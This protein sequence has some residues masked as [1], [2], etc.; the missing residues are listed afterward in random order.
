MKFHN[1]TA[2]VFVPDGQPLDRALARVTHLGIGA[3][4]DDLEFGVL[5]GIIAGYEHRCFAG[6]TCTNGAGSARTGPFANHTDEQMMAV[7]RQEQKRA[8]AIGQYA[9]IF[10][11]DYPSR[12]VKDPN[13]VSLRDDLQ[14]ILAATRPQVVYTHNPA[15]K[16]ETHIGVMIAALQALRALPAQDRPEK[17]YGYESWRSLDWL[18]DAHKVVLDES[19]HVKLFEQLAAVFASQIAGGKRYDVAI[20]GRRRANATMLDSHAADTT[21]EATFALDLTPLVTDPT[22]DMIGYVMGFIDEFR[23]DVRSKLQKRIYP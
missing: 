22:R 4:P 3:H 19:G 10:Q 15:D 13:N 21:T 11:L 6:V 23:E 17:V 18:S 2:D 16:H 1:P 14:Q 20:L 8:A 5:H 12:A 7:R 9:A